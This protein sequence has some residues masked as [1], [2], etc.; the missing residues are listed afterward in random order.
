MSLRLDWL[1]YAVWT[2]IAVT[3]NAQATAGEQTDYEVFIARPTISNYSIQ[4]G[5]PLPSNW[6]SGTTVRW[7]ACRN[8]REPASFVIQARQ[9]LRGV[10]VRISEL[11]GEQGIVPAEAVDIRAVAPCFRRITDWPAS[12]NWLLVH[13][14][15]LIKIVDEPE[16]GALDAES[17]VARAYVKTTV[18]T[19]APMDAET[20]QSADIEDRRQFWLTVHVPQSAPSG[21]YRGSLTI[22]CQ[23]AAARKL[24]IELTVPPFDLLPPEFEYS[25]YYPTWLEG[26]DLKAD[27]ASNYPVLADAQYLAELRNMAEHGCLNPNIYEGPKLAS[28]GTL[29]FTH[30][31][32]ILALRRQA[33]LASGPLYLNGAGPV[34][35]S[36]KIDPQQAQANVRWVR[37]IV[38]WAKQRGHSEVYIMGQD[39][40]TGAQ[41][42]AQREAWQSIHEG[43]GKVF[44]ANYGDFASLVADLLDLPVLLH[45]IHSKLDKLSLLPAEQFLSFTAEVSQAVSP[46]ALLTPEHRKT[47]RTVHKNGFKIFTYMDALSGYTLPDTHRRLRGLALWKADLNGTMTWAYTHIT[48]R[49]HTQAGRV[50]WSSIFCF[51]LRGNE[52][53]FDTLAWEAYREG[54]DDARYLATLRDALTKAKSVERHRQL[55][56]DTHLWL[57]GITPDADLDQWREGMIARTAQ[58]LE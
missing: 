7:T 46:N 20:L 55:L 9:P 35:S 29:D 36:T 56:F 49:P 42:T 3:P 22:E 58:L 13:D 5:K 12:V 43:G 26:G 40:A 27:N 17:A 31:E 34:V 19:R 48:Q 25:V 2:L 44:A 14:P 51:V 38:E 23:N 57:E 6:Q 39:E 30:L 54:Y 16:P 11:R 21:V 33:G 50:D 10:D 45:P 4:P 8:E 37:E 24:A 41:L 53:P 52:Q 18:F 1:K 47:I 28:D 15:N 32:R